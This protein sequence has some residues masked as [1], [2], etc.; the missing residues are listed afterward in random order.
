MAVALNE[1]LDL[2]TLLIVKGSGSR[3]AIRSAGHNAKHGF[4]S[5]S[6]EELGIVLDL[7][8]PESKSLDRKTS[9]ARMGACNNWSEAFTWLEGQNLS[10]IG[11]REGRVGLSVFLLGGRVDFVP[12]IRDNGVK[13]FEVAL[14]NGTILN[15][16][17]EE[18]SDLYLALKGGGIVT[19]VGLQAHPLIKVQ[20]TINMYDPSDSKN[21]LDAFAMVQES[22]EQDPKMGMFINVRRDFIAIGMFYADWVVE[23]PAA[24]DPIVKLGSLVGAAVPTSNGTFSALNEILEEW[25]YKMQDLK[26]AYLTTMT[27]VSHELLHQGYQ[28]WKDIVDQL[29]RAVNVHWSTQPLTQAAVM[30]GRNSG[31]NILGLEKVPQSYWIFACD[32][33]QDQD[34]E[35]MWNALDAAL[36]RSKKLAVDRELLLDPLLPT[37]AGASQ[38]VL[39]GFGAENVKKLQDAARR[40]DPEGVFQKL[41][42]GG[43][44]D[45][46]WRTAR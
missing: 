32:L 21:L 7:R 37:F 36:Q 43:K 26:H 16:N 30:A 31:G 33:K 22:M 42:N 12:L 9:I 20:Y 34:D 6:T 2:D 15:A 23:L 13:N 41:Q 44:E 1:R 5:V 19:A 24:F 45:Q 18:N 35:A 27:K 46:I 4:S 28:I 38:N 11:S 40:Y 10:V 14:A 17:A 8:G 25:A 3:F 39:A 29:P